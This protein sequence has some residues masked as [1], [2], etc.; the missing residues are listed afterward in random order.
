MT[1]LKT[2]V[3]IARIAGPS[4]IVLALTEGVNI[5]A[6]AGIAP[7]GVYL[8]GTILLVAGVAIL[9]AHFRWTRDW[10][11]VVTLLGW[12]LAI[13]GLFRMSMPWA[14]QLGKEPATYAVLA[15]LTAVGMFLSYKGYWTGRK[16][17]PSNGGD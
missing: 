9:Q 15:V 2:S 6:F 8:N 7:S 1:S 16:G 12:T 5:E 10:R 4:L 14:P 17:A 3:S 11:V 13:G